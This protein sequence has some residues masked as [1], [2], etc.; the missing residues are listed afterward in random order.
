LGGRGR[1]FLLKGA[2]RVSVDLILGDEGASKA[3]SVL[4]IIAGQKHG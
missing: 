1:G 3:I 2:V 4:E